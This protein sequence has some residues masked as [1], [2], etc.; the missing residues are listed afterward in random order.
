MKMIICTTLVKDETGKDIYSY[1]V[2]LFHDPNPFAASAG[3]NPLID[4]T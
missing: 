1:P 3:I 2:Y 4:Y